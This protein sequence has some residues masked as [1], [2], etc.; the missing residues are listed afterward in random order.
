[1]PL[2]RL[3]GS[4][5]LQ[6]TPCLVFS[7][8]SE[9]SFWLWVEK[10]RL[11]QQLAG[12]CSWER[13]WLCVLDQ[14]LPGAGEGAE[15]APSGVPAC[16]PSFA[17]DAAMTSC[18]P[19]CREGVWRV[20]ALTQQRWPCAPCPPCPPLATVSPCRVPACELRWPALLQGS[21]TLFQGGSSPVSYPTDSLSHLQNPSLN[22]FPKAGCCFLK[23]EVTSGRSG[24]VL[25]RGE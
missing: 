7:W 25:G 3:L 4:P 21:Q 1:M 10:Q 22:L 9:W 20:Q 15:A 23:P 24:G 12:R 19:G 17:G 2:S 18:W 11:S 14:R 13:C 6:G 5:S 8:T 16:R